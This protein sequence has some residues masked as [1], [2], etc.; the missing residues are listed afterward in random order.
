MWRHWAIVSIGIIFILAPFL[1]LT[2][3]IFK[4]L[5]V[6]GGVAVALLGFWLLSSEKLK[7]S[8]AGQEIK[9]FQR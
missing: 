2:T 4:L 8:S 9:E 5:M 1:G 6:L 7:E 3:F